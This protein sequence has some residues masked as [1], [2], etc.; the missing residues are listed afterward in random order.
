M[1]SLR[2]CR[3]RL[4]N[5]RVSSNIIDFFFKGIGSDQFIREDVEDILVVGDSQDIFIECLYILLV[6][7]FL[8]L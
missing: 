3:Y 4:I 2:N 6:L 1:K 8:D 7:V 5:F